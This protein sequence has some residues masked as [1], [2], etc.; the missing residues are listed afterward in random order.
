[1]AFFVIVVMLVVIFEDGI[2]GNVQVVGFARKAAEVKAPVTSA[3]FQLADK[4]LFVVDRTVA[5]F[6]IRAGFFD[7]LFGDAVIDHIDNTANSTAAVEQG[8]GA[9]QNFYGFC[10]QRFGANRVVS[11]HRGGI[12]AFDAVV[13]Y[14]YPWASL[15][16]NNGLANGGAEGSVGQAGHIGECIAKRGGGLLAQLLA[17]QNGDGQRGLAVGFMNRSRHKNVFELVIIGAGDCGRT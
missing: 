10:Q 4:G 12:G 16:A 1:M 11:A 9:T 7:G 6:N 5:H 3:K 2:A 14:R 15:T 13:Q 8:G 17:G